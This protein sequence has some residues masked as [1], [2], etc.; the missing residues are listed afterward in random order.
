MK[1]VLVVETNVTHYGDTDDATG[2][3]LG[4]TAEF[5]DEMQKKASVLI[6]S[7]LRVGSCHSIPVA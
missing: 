4:E 5:V 1:K 7:V 2:L 3:W 6:L